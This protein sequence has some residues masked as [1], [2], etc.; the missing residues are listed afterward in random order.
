MDSH[1][2]VGTLPNVVSTHGASASCVTHSMDDSQTEAEHDVGTAGSHG[3]KPSM[4]D[5]FNAAIEQFSQSATQSPGRRFGDV[6][7][8]IADQPLAHA[9]GETAQQIAGAAQSSV[10]S[11][12][13][14]VIS[15][16][17]HKK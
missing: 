16:A 14:V 12:G 11:A 5:I 13:S 4:E 6:L 10:A 7:G 9:I 2:G 8:V 1:R 15:A 3:S 17:S